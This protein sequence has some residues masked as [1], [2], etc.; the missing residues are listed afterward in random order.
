MAYTTRSEFATALSQVASERGLDPSVILESLKMAM[1]AAYRRDARE[2]GIA[3]S[4]EQELD[5]QIDSVTGE[6]RV[7][8][9]SEGKKEDITPPGFGRIAAQT[10]K[11]VIL[12]RIHDG[13]FR[14]RR[15]CRPRTIV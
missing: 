10:A 14:V 6:A 9:V 11:Q 5:A 15:F 7:Y 13:H 3:V 4:E 8:A 12:Q 2:R 1:I